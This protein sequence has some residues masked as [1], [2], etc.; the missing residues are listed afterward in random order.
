MLNLTK[1]EKLVLAFLGFAALIGFAANLYFKKSCP[2]NNSFPSANPAESVARIDINK[3]SQEQLDTLPGIGPV[4]SQRIVDFR[5]Q[6]GLFKTLE[7]LR[8]IKGISPRLWQKIKGC[9]FL[10]F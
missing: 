8:S 1:Q 7:D 6:N 10:T 5:Q 2:F 4:L 9:L 3:A